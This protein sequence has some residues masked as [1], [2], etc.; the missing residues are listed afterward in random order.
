MKVESL[1]FQK[2]IKWVGAAIIAGKKRLEPRENAKN[3]KGQ[4]GRKM[5][6]KEKIGQ[7]VK[8]REKGVLGVAKDGTDATDG[9][10]IFS[11]EFLIFN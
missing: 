9:G 5:G 7:M 10:I 4:K 3:A 6:D 2:S 8:S 1:G 11:F